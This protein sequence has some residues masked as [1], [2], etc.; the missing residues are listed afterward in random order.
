MPSTTNGYATNRTNG[1]NGHTHIGRRQRRAD[2]P[3]RLTGQTRFAND[4]LPAGALYT[5]FVR[6][7]YA[8]ATIVSVDTAAA[9]QVPGV[10]AVLTARDLPIPNAEAASEAREILL[11][12]DRVMHV[13]Q[14]VV[15]VLAETEGAAQDAANLITVEYEDVPGPVDFVEALSSSVPVQNNKR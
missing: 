15:A 5:R 3:E 7:P 13:G 9:K 6:S 4:L 1:T 14:P 11:A 2:S 12:F 8:S 10:V